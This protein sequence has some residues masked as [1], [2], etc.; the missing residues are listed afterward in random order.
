[1]ALPLSECFIQECT[2]QVQVVLYLVP[3]VDSDE[4]LLRSV[5]QF[6]HHGFFCA[7]RQ[8]GEGTGRQGVINTGIDW[9]EPP[10][11]P[12]RISCLIFQSFL[13]R[14]HTG[15]HIGIECSLTTFVVNVYVAL[16]LM[17][18]YVR[19]GKNFIRALG[20]RYIPE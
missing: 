20:V 5:L 3:A 8:P 10:N 17:S 7:V 9:L 4:T 16:L 13:P 15:M 18:C 11:A 14:R 1:M 2:L 12:I 19:Q 6:E